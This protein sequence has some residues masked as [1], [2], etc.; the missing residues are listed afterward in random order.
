MDSALKTMNLEK[1]SFGNLLSALSINA[2]KSKHILSYS[3]KSDLFHFFL[4]VSALMA[5]FEQ[6]FENLDVKSSHMEQAM[7]DV[8]TL[9]VPQV[10]YYFPLLR[11]QPKGWLKVAC[12][13]QTH[14]VCHLQQARLKVVCLKK[15]CS[16]SFF[17]KSLRQWHC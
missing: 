4:Q 9:T 13:Q 16:I 14:F 17:K 11:F 1:V 12:E 8:T 7:S 10:S 6:Q 5:K 3:S 2:F 15:F